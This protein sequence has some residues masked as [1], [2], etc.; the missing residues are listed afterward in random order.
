MYISI[1]LT[2]NFLVIIESQNWLVR[3]CIC[4]MWT[5]KHGLHFNFT[6][7][8]DREKEEE[9]EGEREIDAEEHGCKQHTT[10]I[11]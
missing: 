8:N 10:P 1:N 6:S 2:V 4:M 11:S 3:K 7:V 5:N 9:R